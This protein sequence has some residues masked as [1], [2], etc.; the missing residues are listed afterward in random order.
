M[1]F[2]RSLPRQVKSSGCQTSREAGS[3]QSSVYDQSTTTDET[4]PTVHFQKPLSFKDMQPSSGQEIACRNAYTWEH[5]TSPLLPLFPIVLP[6]T[7][8][9]VIPAQRC[10]V[11][12]EGIF[13]TSK[14]I[15]VIQY[16]RVQQGRQNRHAVL[17][18]TH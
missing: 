8:I 16:R 7:A 11:V 15:T 6:L 14:Y 3:V 13:G 18:V 2:A 12:I 1:G 17:V 10:A 9:L 4:L 5:A